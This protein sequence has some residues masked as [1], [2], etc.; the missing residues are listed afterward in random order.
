MHHL[1]TE[2]IELDIDRIDSIQLSPGGDAIKLVVIT[3]YPPML[4]QQMDPTKGNA[5]KYKKHILFLSKKPTQNNLADIENALKNGSPKL[6]QLFE[7][8]AYE[9]FQGITSNDMYDQRIIKEA[10]K[11]L[12]GKENINSNNTRKQ[13]TRQKR[14]RSLYR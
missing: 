12:K 5:L 7:D 6:K 11:S 3:N 9:Q 4:S 10:E 13:G 2:R 8:K 1:S 14:K